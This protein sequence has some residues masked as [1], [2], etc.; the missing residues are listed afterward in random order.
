MRRETSI[1]DVPS[2]LALKLWHGGAL[3]SN[4]GEFWQV[5]NLN[6]KKGGGVIVLAAPPFPS[7]CEQT[8][9]K[10]ETKIKPHYAA[11]AK[12]ITR[13][14]SFLVSEDAVHRKGRTDLELKESITTF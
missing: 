11:F 7:I 14:L 8:K 3:R 4:L 5:Q 12:F 13:A 10:T 9:T 1:F 2:W 6:P